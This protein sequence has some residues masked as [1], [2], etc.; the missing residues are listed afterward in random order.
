MD[1][2]RLTTFALAAA[3]VLALQVVLAVV[4]IALN[5]PSQFDGVGTDAGEEFVTRGTALAPPLLPMVVFAA[6]IA[7]ATREGRWRTLGVVLVCLMCTLFVVGSVGELRAEP[8]DDV[9][10]AVLVASGVLGLL[11]YGA[12]GVYGMRR[13]LARKPS[14]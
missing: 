13:L 1:R 14:Y 2:A 6:G 5:W 8:T 7:L 9:P 10:R 12:L 3:A 11:V 4:S